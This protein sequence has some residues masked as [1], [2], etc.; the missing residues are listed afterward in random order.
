MD[1]FGWEGATLGVDHGWGEHSPQTQEEG[2]ADPNVAHTSHYSSTSLGTTIVL[3]R[4]PSRV[5]HLPDSIGRVSK[6]G[7]PHLPVAGGEIA[8]YSRSRFFLGVAALTLV[9]AG[10]GLGTFLHEI[11]P[12]SL[13]DGHGQESP[14]TCAVCAA[15]HHA[16]GDPTPAL[17][18]VSAPRLLATVLASPASLAPT[19]P[20]ASPASPRAPPLPS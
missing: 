17:T 2:E 8:L 5:E 16:W 13:G 18:G 6:P 1:E 4:G 20:V 19:L 7:R 11:L 3:D 10:L 12:H 15:T 14:L 9:L